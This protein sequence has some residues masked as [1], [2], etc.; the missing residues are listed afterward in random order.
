VLGENAR[1]PAARDD[2]RVLVFAGA[3]VVVV[4]IMVAGLLFLATGGTQDTPSDRTPVFL[5]LERELTKKIEDGGPLYFA[6]PFG[7]NGFWLDLED[8]ALVALDIVRPGSQQCI[9]KWR[10]PRHAYVDCDDQ[11]L[12]SR[13][14]DRFEVIVGKI[15]RNDAPKDAVYVDLRRREPAP[16][17][18]VGGGG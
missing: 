9:V 6:N 12:T 5:G 15:A 1:V 14:L 4:G 7:D 2:R 16:S 17:P 11:D 10:E 18:L 13:D 8:G 3:I